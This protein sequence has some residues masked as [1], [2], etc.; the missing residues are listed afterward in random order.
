MTLNTAG[1]SATAGRQ[2]TAGTSGV[3][4]TSSKFTTGVDDADGKSPIH[5]KFSTDIN[6]TG[7]KYWQQYH[8]VLPTS[9]SE[10]EE[11]IFLCELFCSKVETKYLKL[12]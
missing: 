6:N 1:K 10:L 9:L 3:N 5:Q 11:K 7:G 4:D 2:E 8:T 12:F